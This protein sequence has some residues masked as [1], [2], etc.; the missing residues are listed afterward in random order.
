MD[1]RS[2]FSS[3]YLKLYLKHGSIILR[4]G[5]YY[6]TGRILHT[7]HDGLLLRQDRGTGVLFCNDLFL[8]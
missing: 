5:F 6:I 4:W 3:I 2:F 8:F 7:G 1:C